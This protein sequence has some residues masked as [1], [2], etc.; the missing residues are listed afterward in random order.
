MTARVLPLGAA[1]DDTEALLPWF[2]NGSLA[3]DEREQVARH[4][5]ECAHCRSEVLELRAFHSEYAVDTPMPEAG[6][7]FDRLRAILP[8]RRVPWHARMALRWHSFRLAYPTRWLPWVIAAQL[9]LIV[10][11]GVLV[12]APDRAQYETLGSSSGAA[13]R[14]GTIVVVFAPDTRVDEMRRIV[15]AAD[16]RIIDGPTATDAYVLD[17]PNGNAAAVLQALRGQR[18]VVLAEPLQGGL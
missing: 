8:A 14:S 2:V 10:T 11:L 3:P 9:A 5:E 18:A 16:A 6:R 1:H 17:V 15:R 7:A 13:A 12:V 4:L